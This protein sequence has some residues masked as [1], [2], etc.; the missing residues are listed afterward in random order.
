MTQFLHSE[1]AQHNPSHSIIHFVTVYDFFPKETY[2][3]T[4]MDSP[5]MGITKKLFFLADFNVR[6]GVKIIKIQNLFDG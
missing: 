5:F 3:F 2:N 4:K 6:S 1:L